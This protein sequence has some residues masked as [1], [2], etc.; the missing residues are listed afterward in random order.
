[1]LVMKGLLMFLAK[2]IVTWTALSFALLLHCNFS[3][4]QTKSNQDAPKVETL[5]LEGKTLGNKDFQLSSLKGKVTLVMF[6]S[7]NCPVCRHQMP[8]LR[9]N[10]KGWADKP[11]ELVLVS[12]D[13]SMKDVDDYFNYLNQIIPSKQRFTQLWAGSSNYKDNI[14]AK[15]IAM[16]QLPASY[17]INKNGKVVSMYSGRIPAQAWDEIAELL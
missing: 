14:E 12:V 3:S 17:L 6:W 4:A 1:M 13:K 16:K 10:I 2:K 11:F 9:E 7:T 8:E 5:Q 15:Q